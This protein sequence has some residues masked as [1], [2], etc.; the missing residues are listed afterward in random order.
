MRSPTK[1]TVT[2]TQTEVRQTSPRPKMKVGRKNR[3]IENLVAGILLKNGRFLV[4]KRRLDKEADP[5]YVEIPGGHVEPGETLE[6]ALR[7]EMKEELGIKVE[8]ARMVRKEF[9]IATNGERG[10]IHYFQIEKW[11]D[12]IRSYEAERVFWESDISKLSINADQ[13]AVRALMRTL[14]SDGMG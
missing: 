13:R 7:R 2:Q 3:R 10:R 6:E 8:K 1:T 9:S 5:G 14:T 4:E 11:N 12:R